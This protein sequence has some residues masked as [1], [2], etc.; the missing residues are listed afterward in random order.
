MNTCVPTPTNLP[1]KLKLT[2]ISTII[3][4]VGN[5]ISFI[6]LIIVGS[7]NKLNGVTGSSPTHQSGSNSGDDYLSANTPIVYSPFCRESLIASLAIGIPFFLDLLLD[8][9]ATRSF[10]DYLDGGKTSG[11]VRMNLVERSCFIV[12][13]LMSGLTSIAPLQTRFDIINALWATSTNV[14]TFLC[15][16]PLFVFLDRISTN[17]RNPKQQMEQTLIAGR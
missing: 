15:I 11:A 3:V 6:P 16:V 13:V 17:V 4:V 2:H 9:F 14:T 10:K 1:L 5:I 12:G 8:L 7:S